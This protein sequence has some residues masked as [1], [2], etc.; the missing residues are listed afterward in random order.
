MEAS[1]ALAR[2]DCTRLEE[3]SLSCQALNR[4]IASLPPDEKSG[5]ARQAREAVADMAV[6]ARVL[7]ATRSN[8]KVMQRLRELRTDRLEYRV[9]SAEGCW[10]A[11]GTESEHGNN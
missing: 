10:N 6:F 9:T 8:L 2:I 5:L 11:A 1:L 3:L 4:D 7:E